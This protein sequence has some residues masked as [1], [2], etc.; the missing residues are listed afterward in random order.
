MSLPNLS[1]YLREDE[2][3]QK[4]G[5][6]FLEKLRSFGCDIN[7]LLSGSEQMI[8]EPSTEYKVRQLEKDLASLEE[9][10]E[11]LKKFI[12]NGAAYINRKKLKRRINK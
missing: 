7:W 1:R 8:K 3:G 12:Q 4:P 5:F 9:E 2:G 11:V 10:N 6:E